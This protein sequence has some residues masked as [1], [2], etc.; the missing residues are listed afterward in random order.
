MSFKN[1]KDQMIIEY[2]FSYKAP[3]V[4]YRSI[5]FWINLVGEI[6]ATETK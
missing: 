1:K 5:H 6:N 4:G 3:H 2:H